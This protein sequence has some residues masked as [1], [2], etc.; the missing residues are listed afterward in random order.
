MAAI[1]S[2]SGNESGFVAI[3]LTEIT[4]VL[5]LLSIKSQGKKKKK[6]SRLLTCNY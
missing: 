5:L 3:S 2:S 6:K 1:R 4:P